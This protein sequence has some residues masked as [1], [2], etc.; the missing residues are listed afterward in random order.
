MNPLQEM[1]AK[2]AAAASS[3]QTGVQNSTQLPQTTPPKD[4]PKDPPPDE[5]VKEDLDDFPEGT[6]FLINVTQLMMRG[7]IMKKADA[8]GY[9]YADDAA[10]AERMDY[11]ATLGH[12]ERVK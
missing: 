4:P 2:K 12:C 1:L 3:V 7:G 6:Y 5:P 11:Y 10:Q 8:R 9:V